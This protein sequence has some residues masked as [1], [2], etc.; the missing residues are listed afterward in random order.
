MGWVWSEDNSDNLQLG[1]SERCSTTKVVK[2]QCR[3]EEVQSGKFVRKCEKTEELLRNCVGRP[4]EVLQ[5]NKE[6]T[7]EDI[8]H[9][10]LRG[11]S[12]PFS[13]SNSSSDH[14]VFDFPGLRSDIE[15]LERNLFGGIYRFFE[16]ADEMKNGF[17]DVFANP[18]G[19]NAESSSPSMRRGIPI[20]ENRPP[21]A[22]PRSKEKESA[23]TDFSAMAK[24]V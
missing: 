2:S 19:I 5:S 4:V 10:V 21:E 15:T 8:T 11:G 17:F 24:D 7:E 18:P 9:E 14:G 12:I 3:T 13:S 22:H 1:D 20:E 23:D 6:Y 16:A